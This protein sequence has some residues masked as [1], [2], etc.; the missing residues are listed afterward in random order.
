MF[1]LWLWLWLWL[2]FWSQSY[3]NGN[4][5]SFFIPPLSPFKGY[6]LTDALNF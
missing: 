4:N 3:Q 1:W 6:W 2:W 5:K